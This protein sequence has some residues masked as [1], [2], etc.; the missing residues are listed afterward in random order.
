LIPVGLFRSRKAHLTEVVLPPVV[1][2]DTQLVMTPLNS[3][4]SM[5]H[6]VMFV[7]VPPVVVT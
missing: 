7:T 4:L 3:P 5:T 6:A 2:L 1:S